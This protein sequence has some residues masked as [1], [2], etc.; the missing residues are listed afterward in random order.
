[1]IFLFF[2]QTGLANVKTWGEVRSTYDFLPGFHLDENGS[3]ISDI[4]MFRSRVSMDLQYEIRSDLTFHAGF[5][6]LN[7]QY[8]GTY[9]SLGESVDP[10]PFQVSRSNN[11]DLTNIWP[12]EFYIQKRDKTLGFTLGVQSFQWGLGI[13][14]ND[15]NEQSIWGDAQQGNHYLR[16]SM[17]FAVGAAS[18][19]F[20]A[21]DSVIRD[22]NVSIYHEGRAQQIIT[23]LM[24]KSEKG[25]YGLLCGYRWQKDAPEL[26]HPESPTFVR[27]MPF[28]LYGRTQ[29][30]ENVTAEIEMVHIRGKSNRIYSE[31]TRGEVTKVRSFG[32]LIRFDITELTGFVPTTNR[33]EFGLAS[34]DANPTDSTSSAF[35]IHSNYNPGLI[36][37]EQV[38][39]LLS[40]NS[41]ERLTDKDL[42]GQTAPGLRYGIQQGN[43][44]NAMF[45]HFQENYQ[46]FPSLYF[47]TGLVW[48]RSLAPITDP[49]LTAMNG[50]YNIGFGNESTIS[51]QLGQE[52]LFGFDYKPNLKQVHPLIR[53]D[54]S[55]WRKNE[56]FQSIGLNMLW[57]VHAKVQVNWGQ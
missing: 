24:G 29:L 49:F 52:W 55:W 44:T 28:D 22:D 21:L 42:V 34:G 18:R 12:T 32:G 37:F 23:G 8:A 57:T 2:I 48:V 6:A 3:L 50:G 1:M 10:N 38:L 53:L 14:A 54:A 7:G 47:R 41:V 45:V 43:V 4:S 39:P 11:S 33:L 9:L 31:Q 56:T 27:V 17:D 35:Y 30:L 40:T 15:G 20:V 46:I 16:G 51:D 5:E 13:L 26:S 25:Q 36:I 19:G